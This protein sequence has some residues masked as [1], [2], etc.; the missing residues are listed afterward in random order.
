MAALATLRRR[1]LGVVF[2]GVIVGLLVLS[3]LIYTKFFVNTVDVSLY[4]GCQPPPVDAGTGQT[5]ATGTENAADVT[6]MSATDAAGEAALPTCTTQTLQ[7]DTAGHELDVPAD[8]KLRGIL[9]GTVTNITLADNRAVIHLHLNPG[10][11]KL[12]PANVSAEIVPKTL[13]GEK[14]VDL[15][16][17]SNPSSVDIAHG[18]HRIL[19]SSTSIEAE[20]VFN[21]LVPLLQT[22]H[23]AQLKITL[24]NLAMALQGRGNALG[25]NLSQTDTYLQGINPDLP[26]IETDITGLEDLANNVD[27]ATP[28]LLAM[29]RQFSETSNTLVAKGD[30]LAQFLTGTE[31]F[32][33]TADQILVQNETNIVQLAD[34][35]EP[36]LGLLAEYAP[37]YGC[38]LTG[39]T[40]QAQVLGQ[41]FSPHGSDKQYALHINLTVPADAMRHAYTTADTPKDTAEN[42]EK[43]FPAQFKALDGPCFGLPAVRTSPIDGY[44]P[45]NGTPTPTQDPEAGTPASAT[46]TNASAISSSPS[47]LA[48]VLVAPE[49]GVT[50]SQVPDLDAVLL[51][52]ALEGKDVSVSLVPK[53]GGSS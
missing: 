21:D 46:A 16:I 49:L 51:A 27:A 28:D 40:D 34:T 6:G 39:L 19:Q 12:I 32:A 22:L 10:D 4:A 20:Q 18:D 47:A 26:N 13:F 8:V 43:A 7:D 5:S 17:P 9:V 48:R 44:L 41:V 15:V 33:N 38:V 24:S 11:A 25:E 31:S 2:I 35:G 1:T 14:Y 45:I 23:P 42:V 30:T 37:E 53:G 3:I 36:I 29:A 50:S 52:P